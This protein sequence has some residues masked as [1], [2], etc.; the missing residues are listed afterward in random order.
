MQQITLNRQQSRAIHELGSHRQYRYT[1]F[2]AV[3]AVGNRVVTAMAKPFQMI[4]SC[5]VGGAFRLQDREAE[6]SLSLARTP[7]ENALAQIPILDREKVLRS[8]LLLVKPEMGE[9]DRV[10]L[11][12]AV[13]S[14][15]DKER[16]EVIGFALRIIP[17]GMHGPG[18]ATIL[19]TVRDIPS[20][21]REEVIGKALLL[22]TQEM[23][24]SERVD[25][26]RAV[27]RISGNERNDVIALAL[28]VITQDMKIFSRVSILGAV[29]DV[30]A[31]EREE[32]VGKALLLIT[33]EMGGV[34]RADLIR[35]VA[36]IPGS[37]RNDVIVL[38]LRVITEV[39]KI[40][41][42]VSILEAVRNVPVQEREEVV[43][44][45]LLLMT[46]EM[47]WSERVALIR[48][49]AR[50]PDN[51]RNNVIDFTLQVITQDMSMPSR[52]GILVTVANVPAQ[53]RANVMHHTLEV[54]N[55]RMRAPERIAMIRA[56][57][58]TRANERPHLVRR[59]REGANG[60]IAAEQGVDVHQGDRDQR[61]AAAIALLRERQGRISED[62]IIRAVEEFTEYLNRR[63]MNSEHKQL[64]QH[65][66][67]G[68]HDPADFGPLIDGNDS[69]PGLGIS[70][71]E[72][73]GRLWIFASG[74]TELDQTIAKEG[75][76]SAL[77]ES[78]YMGRVCQEGKVQRL[79]VSVLQGRFP[80]V[81]IELV[82]G[83]QVFK[84]QAM[85]MFFNVEGHKA[86]DQL[87]PLIDAAN[88]FCDE[89]PLVN[90][91]E[92]LHEIGAFAESQGIA[93]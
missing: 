57:A 83:M 81:N 38:A 92:F 72:M 29:R 76:I 35:T 65:A 68:P 63:E 4:G 84:E 86:I 14:L 59:L 51:E 9:S 26:I 15:A 69:I 17:R 12:Q 75:I 37:E 36:D 53:E 19:R 44:K 13:A 93:Q 71:E 1:I 61:V 73:I 85:E 50:I 52:M 90:R 21:E 54:I 58:G 6:S 7:F 43:S 25:L 11:I 42:R 55:D 28:R 3:T 33:Q 30:S 22:M 31:Q 70:G 88:R 48:A 10:D 78:Y 34:D 41:S 27:V 20:Q 62:R 64:A 49:V 74:L 60:R 91:D 40:F 24:W 2:G 46:Q 87:P 18:R 39:M 79:I 45:A 66:L 56:I 77:K 89:N 80:G 8:A 82:E 47:E 32:V 67:Q 16:D 5:F 23:G